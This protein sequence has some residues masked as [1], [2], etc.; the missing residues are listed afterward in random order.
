MFKNG[1]GFVVNE[2]L[3]LIKNIHNKEESLVK[4]FENHLNKI[5]DNNNFILLKELDCWQGRADLVLASMKESCNISFK[6]AEIISNLT[7]AKIISLLHYKAARTLHYIITK[8]Y[9]S[10][11]T[12]LKSLKILIDAEIVTKK[13][14][15][16][17]VL[18]NNFIIPNVSFQAYELKLHNWKRALYQAIQYKGFSNQSSVVMPKKYINSAVKNLEIFKKNGIGLIEIDED[19]FM[20]IL[21]KPKKHQPRR[22]EFHLVGIGKMAIQ[23]NL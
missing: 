13:N 1:V 10:E 17:Y 22:K 16:K 8:T 6:Q 15:D 4:V 20:Y 23:K 3:E 7:N 21:L 14:D 9:L 11:K 19:G 12:I 18:N 2:H 5:I